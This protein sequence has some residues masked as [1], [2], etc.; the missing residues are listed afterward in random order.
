MMQHAEVLEWLRETDPSRLEQLWRRADEERRRAVGDAVHLR[1]LVEISNTCRRH[2]GYCGIRSGNTSVARY[3]M[4]S[5]EILGAARRAHGFGYGTVVLQA[6]EDPGI[7]GDWMAELISRIRAELPVAVTL[8]L[9]ERGEGELAAW[10]A[11]GADRYLLR[12]ETS[13]PDLYRRIHPGFG[14]CHSD[15]L[16]ALRLLKA[17]G[18]EV[19][20]GFLVGVP[21]QTYSDLANDLLLVRELGCHMVGC[22]PFIPHPATPLGAEAGAQLRGEAGREQVPADETMACKVIALARLLCPGTNIPSTTALAT[23]SPGRGRLL[24]LSRGANVVMPNVTPLAYRPKYE[25]YPG[26]VTGI[27]DAE[28]FHGAICA[29][30]LA[31]G[32]TVGSGAGSAPCY[33]DGRR[34]EV[35]LA[36]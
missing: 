23:L 5:G 34:A 27:E 20:S 11:A 8:S 14:D 3:R 7:A 18:Y 9:G 21:G 33:A 12:F 29:E 32:R 13:N 17:L 4:S 19:G 6:G 28:T 26:K 10:R 16:R 30:I 35:E 2:C 36:Q 1:G 31:L 22:G 15:R 25:I 24:G